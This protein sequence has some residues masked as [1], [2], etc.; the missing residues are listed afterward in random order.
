[1]PCPRLVSRRKPLAMLSSL[2]LKACRS[3]K[4]GLPPI[5]APSWPS[6]QGTQP[7][8]NWLAIPDFSEQRAPADTYL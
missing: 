1:M 8:A 7:E 6:K 5:R 3:E 2:W 4:W